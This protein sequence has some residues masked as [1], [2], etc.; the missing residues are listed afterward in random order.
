MVIVSGD[1]AAGRSGSEPT[2]IGTSAAWQHLEADVLRGAASSATVLITGE[3]GVGKTLVARAIH[4]QSLRRTRPFIVINCAAVSGTILERQ[5]FG[6]GSDGDHE[7]V[8]AETQA[9]GGTIVLDDV[10]ETSARGQ[11]LLLRFF[12]VEQ[13]RVGARRDLPGPVRIIATTSRD[14]SADVAD[15]TFQPELRRRLDAICLAIPPLRERREDIESLLRHFLAAFSARY[16]R[17]IPTLSASVAA[18]LTAYDWP[19][20]DRELKNVAERLIVGHFP[21]IDRRIL[22]AALAPCFGWSCPPADP[23]ASE[24]KRSAA[25]RQ[26][27]GSEA[28][29]PNAFTS[30]AQSRRHRPRRPDKE[31]R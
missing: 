30:R 10:G 5:L 29:S 6:E 22:D 2:L 17:P 16:Q 24:R 21:T 13:H 27:R 26:D 14:L 25:A 15:G 20:N 1:Y 12:E 19:G 23:S 3:T 18:H 8:R 28:G 11:I 31:L 4:A 9:A 7:A